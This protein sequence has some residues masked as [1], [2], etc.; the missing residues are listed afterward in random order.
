MIE[1]ISAH[2]RNNISPDGPVVV[3]GQPGPL[4]S[5]ACIA[6]LKFE[7]PYL[8]ID[9]SYPTE[10]IQYI[11]NDSQ[12]KIVLAD[13][14]VSA[15]L[16]DELA[17]TASLSCLPALEERGRQGD[18]DSQNGTIMDLWR[19]AGLAEGD[20]RPAY[21]IY[22]SGST[23]APKGIVVSRGN[24]FNQLR[25]LSSEGHLR[26][27]VKILQKTPI[28]FDAAQWE[29]LAPLC[30]A[31]TVSIAPGEHR[32][33]TA[34]VRLI[35]EESVTSLQVV[36]TL[37]QALV[38]VGGL[39]DTPTLTSIY[40]GGE[41]LSWRLV[42]EVRRLKPQATIVNL[43]G[44][45]ECTINASSYAIRPEEPVDHPRG[46][47]V[48]L[49]QPVTNT[50]F[51]IEEADDSASS[52]PQE[53]VG[54]LL[55]G[56]VQVV[57]GYLG[58]ETETES[59][60]VTRGGS[61][62]YRTGD[63]VR[64]DQYG[65]LL[66]VGRTD[67]QVKIRGNRVELDELSTRYEA[68]PWVARAQC[69]LVPKRSNAEDKELVACIQLDSNAAPL[70]DGAKAEGHHR[71]KK[72]KHQVKAQL[73]NPGLRQDFRE[74]S[75]E[76]I[77]S[78]R[79]EIAVDDLRYKRKSYRFFKPT[80]S[81]SDDL[82]EFW[83][84]LTGK[85]HSFSRPSPSRAF[86][87]SEAIQAAL[88]SVAGDM[89]PDRLLP[90]YAYASPGALY[91]IQTYVET[92][93][94]GIVDKGLYYFHPL[95]RTL[96]AVPGRRTSNAP[97][98][99]HLVSKTHAIESVYRN[100]VR[101]VQYF[102]LGH[103]LGLVTDVLDVLGI[104][105]KF[106]EPET[107]ELFSASERNDDLYLGYLEIFETPVDSHSVVDVPTLVT[108]VLHDTGEIAKGTYAYEADGTL[109][110]LS[111]DYICRS[112]VIAI[113]QSVYDRSTYGVGLYFE[114]PTM[115]AQRRYVSLGAALHRLQ[116]QSDSF[117][118]MSSGYSSFSGNPLPAATHAQQILGINSDPAEFAFYFALSG[119]VSEHQRT[120]RGMNEDAVHMSGP[121][122]IV[123]EELASYVPEYMIPDRTV[124]LASM[125][126]TPN[127]KVDLAQLRG[128]DEVRDTRDV[129][130]GREPQGEAE[131]AVH[132]AWTTVLKTDIISAEDNF[133]TLGGD[134]I[135]VMMVL[136]VLRKHF[137][138]V[139]NPQL[140]FEYPVLEDLARAVEAGLTTSR[141]LRL[142]QG[143]E[144]SADRTVIW[145]GLGGVPYGLRPLAENLRSEGDVLGIQASGINPNEPLF[146]D[147][148]QMAANDLE[149]LPD[150]Y[151]YHIVGY[152]FGCRIAYTAASMLAQE[153]IA[154]RSL[155]LVC[156]GNPTL[157]QDGIIPQSGCRDNSIENP[158]FLGMLLSVFENP[159]NMDTYQRARE[160]VTSIEDAADFIA[161]KHQDFAPDQVRRIVDLIAETY[162]FDYTFDEMRTQ[163]VTCPVLVVKAT[164][165]QYSSV[166]EML[167]VNDT[168]HE[169]A[170][171]A[172]DHYE[173][174]KSPHV[175]EL[176]RI[177]S[178][179]QDRQNLI[180]NQK[181]LHAV[182]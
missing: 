154:V 134:S 53:A 55:I 144:E 126:T 107:N 23:G 36:P 172:A 123:T 95:K 103:Y 90:K 66:F 178:A 77:K 50:S 40:A 82:R 39:E 30:D 5:A 105:Y 29:I 16:L 2:L 85:M 21:V 47:T 41:A 131:L 149:L 141:M 117:G 58:R 128:L 139:V 171:M 111:E 80:N 87:L 81:C 79:V 97:V 179:F 119:P 46:A 164:G 101:E 37:L 150:D 124:V 70:M 38:D 165:D 127:G 115:T 78:P 104:G 84:I 163:Q 161:R 22:T 43:Y 89:N 75:E 148:R 93:G 109:R 174:L 17:S 116:A 35:R 24:L 120:H 98:R 145:P 99:M 19:D 92:S 176:G 110:Q 33:P 106:C 54:E 59:K 68:H 160:C 133:F 14:T 142:A 83:E 6:C 147:I 71:S 177:I 67:N 159:L 69:L 170:T 122:E 1:L 181:E 130:V 114:D 166:D 102:E 73:S 42:Q 132:R 10:R 152:S 4:V 63:L 26:A 162:R 180:H 125:P 100:N 138:S 182:S 15:G 94:L 18:E 108:C 136:G 65:D 146:T 129:G 74:I 11:L 86:T 28:G 20:T 25:W 158:E 56:G 167:K 153:G 91:S 135:R 143:E 88:L 61:K 31:V 121:A 52:S 140:L 8:P 7:V 175:K 44:P 48:P 155:S 156:P 112:D 27:G 96:Q 118:F 13:A 9:S 32:D 3:I 113:N 169:L 57:S 51:L 64:K 72:S 60:F 49:G 168:A 173:V 151:G 34:L 76:S 157:D 62:Y 45:S 137:G 12:A